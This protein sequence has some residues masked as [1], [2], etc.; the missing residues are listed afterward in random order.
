MKVC[1]KYENWSWV[2]LRIEKVI[3][4][5]FGWEPIMYVK[6][7]SFVWRVTLTL[8]HSY[9]ANKRTFNSS[10]VSSNNR[11]NFRSKYHEKW[12]FTMSQSW[13]ANFSSSWLHAIHFRNS[14]NG[15][16]GQFFVFEDY[17]RAMSW[18]ISFY[19]GSTIAFD[20]S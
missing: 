17:S 3:L 20:Q 7:C 8:I 6:T 9:K 14:V 19:G 1:H 10:K 11:G 4:V 16:I 18:S 12:Y 15:F 2:I 13:N 5:N